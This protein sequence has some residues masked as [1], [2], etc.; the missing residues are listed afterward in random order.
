MLGGSSGI[1]AVEFDPLTMGLFVALVGVTVV[2][3]FVSLVVALRRGMRTGIYCALGITLALT[4]AFVAL[5]LG[6]DDRYSWD[7]AIFAFA[8]ILLPNV[9]LAL[10]GTGVST[11]RRRRGG[12]S[13]M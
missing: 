6:D 4:L 8:F 12:H 7:M 3:P 13:S 11:I 1:V 5:T 2:S 9:T 10:V